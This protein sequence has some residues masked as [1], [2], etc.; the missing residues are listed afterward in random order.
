ME[1]PL[2]QGQASGSPSS[3]QVSSVQTCRTSG[4]RDVVFPGGR[5]H[6]SKLPVTWCS[7]RRK[8]SGTMR[9]KRRHKQHQEIR[10]EQLNIG[11]ARTNSGPD[12]TRLKFQRFNLRVKLEYFDLRGKNRGMIFSM[13]RLRL[14]MMNPRPC[15]N[16]QIAS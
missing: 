2:Q 13:N 9:N 5:I 15:G 14:R 4:L 16:Q 1:R 8:G 12:E 7:Q 11:S 10:S 6:D 3:W